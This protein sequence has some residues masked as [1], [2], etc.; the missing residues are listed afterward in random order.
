MDLNNLKTGKYYMLGITKWGSLFSDPSHE[1]VEGLCI[2]IQVYEIFTC[3][4]LV[5][6]SGQTINL[7]DHEIQDYVEIPQQSPLGEILY[8]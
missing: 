7:Y 4:I 5:N 1:S 6:D 2:E 8:G 3:F